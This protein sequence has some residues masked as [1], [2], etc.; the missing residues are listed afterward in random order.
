MSTCLSQC[1]DLPEVIAENKLEQEGNA[2]A[3]DQQST[4]E[5]FMVF[6]QRHGLKIFRYEAE[7]ARNRVRKIFKRKEMISRKKCRTQ[8]NVRCL[9]PAQN[10]GSLWQTLHA[11]K[12]FCHWY[13][14]CLD[15]C[16]QS[17]VV[18]LSV[19]CHLK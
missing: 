11:P 18:S 2:F 4:K 15:F 13:C 1:P 7:S 19:L 17:S 16:V 10:T 6:K 9:G 3:A 5:H 14:L 8:V 12:V